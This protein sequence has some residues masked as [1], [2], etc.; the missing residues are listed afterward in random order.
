MEWK[1]RQGN[2]LSD[3]DEQGNVLRFFYET[4]F[5]GVLLRLLIRKPVSDFA[6]WFMQRR[7]STLWIKKFL[8]NSHINMEEYENRKFVSFNDFFT[9]RIRPECR[10]ID[11]EPTHFISPCDCKL[12]VFPINE[13][14]EF[15]IKGGRYTPEQLL[16]S[17]ELARD[18]A[19]GQLLVFR[20]TVD[21]Y[22]RY[23]YPDSGVKEENVHIQGVY[24]TVNPIAF[25]HYAVFKE[26]TREYTVLHSDHFDDLIMM[27]V[28]ATLVG[29]IANLHGAQRVSRGEEKGHF[30]FGGSTIVVF[31][32]PG[33]LRVDEDIMRNNAEG[34]ET[35]VKYG[36]RIGKKQ[37]AHGERD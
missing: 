6:G 13:D 5:G 29:R 34:C 10:P 8:K 37:D 12:T 14:S 22:H 17:K 35:V 4:K 27:E 36:E 18:Y 2:H 32:K 1:D 25:K 7:I 31:V 26:N 19:G 30:D 15:V 9:R 24:Y 11:N 28:G 3:G 33:V 21:D 16:R 23:C 20:L